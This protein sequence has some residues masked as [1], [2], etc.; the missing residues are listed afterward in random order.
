MK[1]TTKILSA[2]LLTTSLATAQTLVTVDGVAI[3][4]KDVDTALMN[5]TQGRFNEVPAEK[6]AQFRKQVLEQLVAKELVYADAKKI[7]ILKSKEFK[8]E[9]T[10]VQARV[11]KEL[12]I[13]V[14]QKK[15]LDKVKVSSKEL[16]NYYNE[17]KEEFKEK[18]RVHARHILV[19][20]KAEAD[21][22]IKG[23][24][25]LKGNAL[26]EKFIAQ[27]K[28]KSTGP[29]GPKGGDLGYFAQGQMVP[30]FNKTVFAMKVGTISPAVKTQFGYHIIYLEDKKK[31][32]NLGFSEV[33]SFIEQRLKL[34]KFKVT[35]KKKMKELQKK[36]KIK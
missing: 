20:T 11:K 21:S 7:G 31:A 34:E 10:K 27:A 23:L 18:E 19:K 14:W 30:E 13:Q 8:N 25:S 33:K 9:Y 12:A 16:K 29:S 15:Q 24:K 22:I 6:Q 28:A 5:A 36:A 1:L 26:K 17:N 32:K 2:I 4:K 35:M 3:T